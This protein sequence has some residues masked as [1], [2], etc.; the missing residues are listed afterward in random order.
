MNPRLWQIL[1]EIITEREFQDVQWGG[2]DHDDEH[3][4]YEWSAFIEK[5]LKKARATEN[6]LEREKQM[7]N[8]AALAVA[9]IES[10]RRQR[11]K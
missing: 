6:I 8:I 7:R 11:G 1:L 3:D 4:L 5:Q 10:S 9:A 2:P